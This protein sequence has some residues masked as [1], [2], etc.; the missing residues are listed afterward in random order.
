MK[1]RVSIGFKHWEVYD[2]EAK[3]REE[4][5]EKAVEMYENGLGIAG[6]DEERYP[7]IDGIEEVL[8]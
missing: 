7:E 8:C 6:W 1:Y 5:K 2:V 3:S 4:A